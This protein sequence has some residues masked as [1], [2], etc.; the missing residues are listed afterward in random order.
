MINH[1]LVILNINLDTQVAIIIILC[2]AT[3]LGQLSILS[4]MTEGSDVDLEDGE[5]MS[6][7]EEGDS[8]V[9]KVCMGTCTMYVMS[10]TP[11]MG[12]LRSIFSIM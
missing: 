5:L 4:K 9:K 1:S 7:D 2:L 12:N 6:S 3:F 8:G 10:K 11:N